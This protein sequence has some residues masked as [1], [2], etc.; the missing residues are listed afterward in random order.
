MRYRRIV[1]FLLGIWLG[2]SAILAL[3]AYLDFDTVD[4]SV[5]S[6]PEPG[7]KMLS[8]PRPEAV[9][10]ILRYGAGAQIAS[11]YTAWEYVQLGLGL[12][13]T[14][15]LFSEASTRKWSAVSFTMTVLVVFL[16]LWITPDLASLGQA[17][18]FLRPPTEPFRLQ[19]WK[20]HN[21]YGI[22]EGIKA[23]LGTGLA[24]FLLVHPG[25]RRVRR[26]RHLSEEDK[27]AEAHQGVAGR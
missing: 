1:L 9:R 5:K 6:L 26:R 16:R 3:A 11:R 13:I 17:I 12:L 24:V 14:A 2:V 25:G 23:I 19:F 8:Q 20:L 18:E 10:A 22:V 4:V 21:V 15:L 27:A 7:A